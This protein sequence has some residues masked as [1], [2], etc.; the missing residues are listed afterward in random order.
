MFWNFLTAFYFLSCIELCLFY[1]FICLLIVWYMCISLRVC[2]CLWGVCMHVHAC[3]CISIFGCWMWIFVGG[4]QRWMSS[5]L[6]SCSSTL[7]ICVCVSMSVY[8]CVYVCSTTWTHTEARG[9]PPQLLSISFSRQ[10]LSLNLELSVFTRLP[11]QW[12]PGICLS[13]SPVLWFIPSPEPSLEHGCCMVWIH[14]C[15][16]N[17]LSTQLSLSLSASY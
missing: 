13:L 12:V 3:V 6:L 10:C 4:S 14:A 11:C 15:M 16:A 7:C 17:T 5:V 1:L 2:L 9:W 8:V